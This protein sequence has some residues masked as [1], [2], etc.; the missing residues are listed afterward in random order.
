MYPNSSITI[1]IQW[2]SRISSNRVKTDN[3]SY[4]KLL[5][6]YVLCLKLVIPL[7]CPKRSCM[8][9][10]NFWCS[11]AWFCHLQIF[12]LLFS[13]KLKDSLFKFSLFGEFICSF[14]LILID[15]FLEQLWMHTL[16]FLF[17]CEILPPRGLPLLL[18][19][20]VWQWVPILSAPPPL[21]P[22]HE[23][24]VMKNVQFPKPSSL[25]SLG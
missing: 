1:S 13:W 2:T 9:V 8:T 22:Y 21:T 10:P 25:G 11:P 14:N 18:F 15:L 16:V 3:I 4:I 12:S 20:A 19:I 6:N 7:V 24:Q 17:W 5:P 23:L